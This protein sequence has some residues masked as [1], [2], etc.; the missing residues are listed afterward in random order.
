MR[1]QRRG[2]LQLPDDLLVA[3]EVVDVAAILVA[4][5]ARTGLAGAF[6]EYQSFRVE[7]EPVGYGAV[8]LRGADA[9]ARG[10]YGGVEQARGAVGQDAR[11]EDRRSR[12]IAVVVVGEAG[13][14]GEAHRDLVLQ[15]G[16]RGCGVGREGEA[17]GVDAGGIVREDRTGVVPAVGE[18]V[19]GTGPGAVVLL[20]ETGDLHVGNRPQR[21]AGG[22]VDAVG[23]DAA[24][25]LQTE[26]DEG[27]TAQSHTGGRPGTRVGCKDL[28]IGRR[29][30]CRRE[31]RESGEQRQ[32]GGRE[33]KTMCCCPWNSLRFAHSRA[34]AD[35]KLFGNSVRPRNRGRQARGRPSVRTECF[36][37]VTTG[38]PTRPPQSAWQRG[39]R[40]GMPEPG[41]RFGG[42]CSIRLLGSSR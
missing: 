1:H 17:E 16:R 9:G 12:R 35:S 28:T 2:Q 39:H 40:P 20:A 10:R 24:D 29:D 22:V 33:A 23:R 25:A 30:L 36:T 11:R 19:E 26:I 31:A 27:R 6:V 32:G 7:G 4:D 13:R 21:L 42:P 38:A 18:E 34:S 3:V 41:V 5:P 8:A 15:G 37:L 14:P